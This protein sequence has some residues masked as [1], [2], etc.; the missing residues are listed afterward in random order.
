LRWS[1]Y[2]SVLFILGTT[3]ATLTVAFGGRSLW[4]NTKLQKMQDRKYDIVQIIQ[5]GPEKEALKTDYLA[6]LLHLSTDQPTSLYA[7]DVRMAI[8]KLLASPLIKKASIKRVFPNSLYIDYEV[9]QPIA[10]LIDYENIAIDQEGYLFPIHPFFSSQEIPELYL[11]LPPFG[12][13]PDSFG[14]EG[15]MWLKPLNN[16][17]FRLGMEILTFLRSISQED[18]MKIRRIDVSNAQA[19]SLGQRE[20]VLTTEEEFVLHQGCLATFPKLLRIAPKDYS[21]QIFSFLRLQ[22]R[23]ED[24]YR[25]QL[26]FVTQNTRFSPRIVDLRIPHLAFVENQ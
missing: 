25:R 18:R 12:E 10:R 3:F 16:S 2:K 5:T 17:F 7:F 24:D 21:E 9:R 13:P 15:G 20:I 6:E 4:K 11:G 1:I 26:S 22:K 23:M 14:R 19:P 8:E